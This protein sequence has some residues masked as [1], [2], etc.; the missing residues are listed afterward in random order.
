M[1]FDLSCVCYLLLNIFHHSYPAW[2]TPFRVWRDSKFNSYA[3]TPTCLR[4]RPCP[5]GLFFDFLR[6]CDALTLRISVRLMSLACHFPLLHFLSVASFLWTMVDSPAP[7]AQPPDGTAAPGAAAPA[8]DPAA[9]SGDT[10][11][12]KPSTTD[13]NAPAATVPPATTPMTNRNLD[14]AFQ[15]NHTY[16]WH[17]AWCLLRGSRL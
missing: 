4:G 9:P 11:S 16:W 5:N 6:L 15:N 14:T 10:R 13:P 1:F 7:A 2:T 3:A 8:G 17:R 12:P